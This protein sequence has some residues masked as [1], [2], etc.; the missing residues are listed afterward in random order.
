MNIV[1]K[2]Q[3]PTSNGLGV[4]TF[5]D[6]EEKGDSVTKCNNARINDKAFCRTAPA[7]PGLLNMMVIKLLLS[8]AS[9]IL[10]LL[11]F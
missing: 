5:E 10:F 9:H 1:S 8:I 3:L 4:M 11:Q 2:F 6:P 7:S